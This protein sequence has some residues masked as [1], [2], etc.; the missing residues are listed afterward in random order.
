M[1]LLCYKD[2]WIIMIMMLMAS[3]FFNGSK[4]EPVLYVQPYSVLHSCELLTP[5]LKLVKYY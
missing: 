2:D 1:A 4:L 5:D 3:L